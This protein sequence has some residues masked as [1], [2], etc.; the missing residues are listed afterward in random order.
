MG[1]DEWWLML[2]LQSIAP[3]GEGSVCAVYCPC[4]WC[5][6]H[7][8]VSFLFLQLPAIHRTQALDQHRP[9]SL[10]RPQVMVV[11]RRE[12]QTPDEEMKKIVL[13]VVKQCVG[14]EGVE[15]DYIRAEILPD[16][17]RHF[18][19]RKMALD[20]R[21][22]KQLV[23][24]TVEISIKVRCVWWPCVA[25]VQSLCVN[26]GIEQDMPVKLQRGMHEYFTTCA[27]CDRTIPPC[28]HPAGWLL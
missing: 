23:E 14:T 15:C 6:G 2:L 4:K 8:I 27:P 28:I 16:F 12:F 25:A 21:N 22:Y 11:L 20:R 18:W 3:G 1:Y 7:I 19:N 17:F 24:T 13:K 10:P 26:V 5:V 9:R